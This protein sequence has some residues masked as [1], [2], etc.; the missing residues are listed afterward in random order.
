MAAILKMAAI[1]VTGRIRDG[2][3]SKNNQ[4]G[5]VYLWTKFHAC[6][7]KPTILPSIA[8]ICCTVMTYLA[9]SPLYSYR[10]WWNDTPLHL[11]VFNLTCHQEDVTCMSDGAD[12]SWLQYVWRTWIIGNF[13]RLS[14]T[15]TV[16]S[17]ARRH[18]GLWVAAPPF[19]GRCPPDENYAV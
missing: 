5:I 16:W 1:F 15:L 19:C 12:M 7:I 3:M 14:V 13:L 8:P 11:P 10:W 2:P 9:I 17:H 4:L 6:F 18:G